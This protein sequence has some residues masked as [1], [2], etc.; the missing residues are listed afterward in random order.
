MPLFIF[1]PRYREMLKLVLETERFFCIGNSDPDADPDD[2]ERSVAAISTAG[3][4]R[5]C[6]THDDGTSHLL[7]LGTQRIR[8]VE[9]L[10]TQPYRVALV[11]PIPS[12]TEAVDIAR[13]L[14]AEAIEMTAE[15]SGEGSS[16]SAKVHSHLQELDDPSAVADVIA[17]NFVT[18]PRQRQQLLE[19]VEV[20]E[21][22]HLLTQLLQARLSD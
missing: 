1:E 5:A 7:L 3:M 4:I 15:L 6:V 10:Q 17:H 14:S 13:Q 8:L 16:M 2:D 12:R 22:L 19:T 18:E 9:F 11:E 20:G 21:R